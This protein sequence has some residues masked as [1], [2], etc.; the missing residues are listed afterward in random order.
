MPA[1]VPDIDFVSVGGTNVN[2]ARVYAWL[3]APS[4]YVPN[5]ST[6]LTFASTGR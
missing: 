5:F 6:S 3:Y 1:D 4:S 2:Y